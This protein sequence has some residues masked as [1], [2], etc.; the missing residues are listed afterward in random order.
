MTHGMP[1]LVHTFAAILISEGAD[2]RD[3]VDCVLCLLAREGRQY[4]ARDVALWLDDAIE[5]VKNRPHDV[6]EVA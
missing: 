1:P 5:A 6:L 3:Q 4:S 2:L